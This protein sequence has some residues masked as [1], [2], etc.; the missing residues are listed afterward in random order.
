[1]TFKWKDCRVKLDSRNK[2]IVETRSDRRC[3]LIAV[4]RGHN[5]ADFGPTL[6]SEKLAGEH[7]FAFSSETLRKWMIEDG[8]WFDRKQS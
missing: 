6:A 2:C 1:M 5:Y 4:D 8:L 7:G 3:R